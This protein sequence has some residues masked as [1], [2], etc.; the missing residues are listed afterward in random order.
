MAYVSRTHGDSKP[1]FAIDTLNGSGSAT[2]GV[3]VQI[4]GPKL[5]FTKIMVR[6]GSAAVNIANELAT[7][8]AVDA[9][10]STITQLATVHFYQ[11]E[12]TTGQLSIATYPVGAWDGSTNRDL[13]VAIRALG[14][15]VGIGTGSGID[16]TGT[17]VTSANNFKLA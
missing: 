8:G 5:E 12:A 10:I 16:V 6:D 17:T 14:S 11:V 7:G 13:Q 2:T 4:A 1:V 9:I 15:A 3:A